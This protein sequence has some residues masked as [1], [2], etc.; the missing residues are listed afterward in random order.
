MVSA[1]CLSNSFNYQLHFSRLRIHSCCH[2]FYQHLLNIRS[3]KSQGLWA[4]AMRCIDYSGCNGKQQCRGYTTLSLHGPIASGKLHDKVKKLQPPH[5]VAEKLHQAEIIVPGTLIPHSLLSREWEGIVTRR[6]ATK[7]NTLKGWLKSATLQVCFSVQHRGQKC[8]T[9]ECYKL[10]W[11]RRRCSSKLSEGTDETWY[12]IQVEVMA[13]E[14]DQRNTGQALQRNE[15]Y[16]K[17][18]DTSWAWLHGWALRVSSS[19]PQTQ[20]EEETETGVVLPH[21]T[22]ITS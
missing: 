1:R 12:G 8:F 20:N 5:T 13:E 9:A 16:Q 11:L 14:Q 19:L 4:V 7:P 22:H 10:H 18:A 21:V 17:W 15:T 2:C 6:G 3:R